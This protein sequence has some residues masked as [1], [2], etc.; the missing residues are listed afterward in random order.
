[1]KPNAPFQKEFSFAEIPKRK[2]MRKTMSAKITEATTTMMVLLCNS[3]QVGHVTLWTISLT[4][5]SI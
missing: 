1:M 2:S 4:V 3:F 5:S